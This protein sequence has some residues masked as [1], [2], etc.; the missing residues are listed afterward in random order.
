MGSTE[1]VTAGQDKA[2]HTAVEIAE[3]ARQLVEAGEKRVREDIAQRIVATLK[4]AQ[5][6]APPPPPARSP[7]TEIAHAQSNELFDVVALLRAVELQIDELGGL[8]M[9][10]AD[11][12]VAHD[13]LRLVQ[14]AT[15]R[16]K[17]TIE[18]FEPY[19]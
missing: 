4:E 17:A 15:D 10:M 8:D 9:L 2:E 11:R 1:T 13:T 19:I 5:E 16:V 3:L 7:L 18:A 14:L 12:T 6:P